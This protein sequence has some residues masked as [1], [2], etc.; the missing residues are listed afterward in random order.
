MSSGRLCVLTHITVEPWNRI[1]R[2]FIRRQ[3]RLE[4]QAGVKNMTISIP[5]I[6]FF[7]KT[8]RTRAAKWVLF[9]GMVTA[10]AGMPHSADASGARMT[11]P[12]AYDGVWNV[13]FTPKA[14]NCHASNSIPFMVSG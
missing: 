14:G 5:S 7:N 9:A 11:G 6:A 10:I 8:G 3:Q 12:G 2:Q 1:L 13:M 4:H